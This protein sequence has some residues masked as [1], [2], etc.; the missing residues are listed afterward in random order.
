[1]VGMIGD[2]FMPEDEIKEKFITEFPSL[3]SPDIKKPE[4]ALHTTKLGELI[5]IIS[6]NLKGKASDVI[7]SVKV[8]T[9]VRE[10]AEILEQQTP[11]GKFIYKKYIKLKEKYDLLL[12]TIKVKPKDQ[13]MVF[14]YK[15]PDYSFSAEIS[16]E[17]I[18][19]YPDKIILVVW[20]YG[21]EY[22]CSLRSTKICLPPLIEKALEGVTGYGGGHDHAAGACVKITDF[23][24][25]VENIRKQL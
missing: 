18:Y 17:L 4:V 25:F 15:S 1:M 14:L 5:R 19:K 22:K 10:P 23:N 20:E 2:W 24:K 21:G 13:L 8:L 3:L 12:E 9:R 11:G 7:K 6:F 16:N